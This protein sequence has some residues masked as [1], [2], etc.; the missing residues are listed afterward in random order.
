MD[1]QDFRQAIV[2]ALNRQAAAYERLAAGIEK[3]SGSMKKAGRSKEKREGLP[4]VRG[5]I[6]T[7][8]GP[9]NYGFYDVVIGKDKYSTKSTSVADVA[10]DAYGADAEVEIFYSEKKNEKGGK[11]YTNRYIE[12][13]EILGSTQVT[14]Q[15]PAL[16]PDETPG[17]ALPDDDIT[18]F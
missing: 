6:A 5:H 10:G 4:S 15:K 3:L 2:D 17:G 18:P 12:S 9:N 11:T 8:K 1:E 16:P 13:I 14:Q 7:F